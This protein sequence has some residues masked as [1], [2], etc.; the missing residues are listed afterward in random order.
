MKLSELYS[1]LSKRIPPALSEEWD[2]DGIMCLP[3]DKEVNRILL[4]LDATEKA[5]NKAIDEKFDL[6]VTHHPMIFHPIASISNKKHIAII[7]GNVAVFSFHTRFDAADGGVNDA[8]CRVLGLKN[9]EKPSM[10]RVGELENEMPTEDFAAWVKK[11]L[12]CKKLTYVKCRDTVKR[13][14]VLGGDGKD[15]LSEAEKAGADTYITGNMSYNTMLDAKEGC[16]N[17]IEAGHYET[18]F[19]SMQAMNGILKEI[20]PKFET[21]IYDNNPIVTI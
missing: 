1:E 10:M 5:V 19:P 3:H 13:V 20:N 15:F 21:E 2:N 12:N 6:I 11:S 8:L 4:S 16:V 14:A 18:E 7:E 17:V 9:I